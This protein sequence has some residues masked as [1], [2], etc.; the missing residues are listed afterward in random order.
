MATIT[1]FIRVATSKKKTA[2][3][4]FRLRDGRNVQLLYA[5]DI[6][7]KPEYW[8]AK[9]EEIKAKVV[10][11]PEEKARFNKNVSELKNLIAEIYNSAIDKDGLTS[12]WLKEEI[13]KAQHP[14]KYGIKEQ[15]E[16][17]IEAFA[18]F[19]ETRNISDVRKRNFRV[20]YRALQRFEIYNRLYSRPNFT[21]AFDTITADTL[22]KFE[23]FLKTEYQHFTKDPETK[24]LVCSA[25]FKPVFE[26]V[27]ET[28]TPA[29]RGQNTISDIFTK[30][31]TFY[32]WAIETGLTNN[33]PFKNYMIKECVYGTPYYITIEE[34]NALY[35]ADLADRPQL[36]IQ[37]DIFVFQ[38]LIGCRVGDL[39]KLT[40]SNVINGAIEYVPRK[41]KEGRPVTVR[42]PLNATAKEILER[43]TSSEG[44]E[45]LP[46][47]SEQ[48]YNVAI[49]K[50]FTAAGITRPVTII[51][52]TTR[53]PEVRP[54][55]EIA[56]SHLA[57]RCFVGNLYK[58]VKDPNLVGALSGHKE[59]SRAF[60]RYREIDEEM[61]QNLVDLLV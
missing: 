51:N 1:A 33:N 57:R 59:G 32:L 28:R 48:K 42:V 17:F 11:N 2:N 53:E 16:T 12:A 21:L 52:P 50:A 37:R 27:P 54:I 55:N 13:D 60:A 39:Y 36:A 15:P 40:R 49:K 6:E 19:I 7:V 29:Q 44:N 58:Q 46:F 23:D 5:S 25:D 41:T 9:R 3:V 35:N 18:R 38:C 24:K 14:E 22:R 56:S 26:A 61:K 45:L 34:R 30:L 47:I 10:M 4:R 31:R 8:D 20:I 43:Y